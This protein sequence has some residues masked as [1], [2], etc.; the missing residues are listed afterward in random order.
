M[1]MCVRTVS[2]ACM[3]MC[4]CM[5]ECEGGRCLGRWQ[6]R[7]RQTPLTLTALLALRG[8]QGVPRVAEAQI[9]AHAVDAVTFSSTRIF[10][11]LVFICA[12]ARGK[13]GRQAVTTRSCLP[14]PCQPHGA[15]G[16]QGLSRAARKPSPRSMKDQRGS[17][18]AWQ[19]EEVP[20]YQ[21]S[22]GGWGRVCS[23]GGTS[24]CIPPG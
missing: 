12:Q 10:Q 17:V 8:S 7:A 4:M 14:A 1:Y 15:A 9:G 20:T 2:A 23:Q 5:R 21:Y 16:R 18:E 13:E 22:G 6:P 11:A 24:S 19:A 3:W